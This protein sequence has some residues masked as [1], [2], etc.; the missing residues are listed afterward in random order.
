MEK[1]NK[2][3]RVIVQVVRDSGNTAT[4]TLGSLEEA[5]GHIEQLIGSEAEMAAGS[6][7]EK[8]AKDK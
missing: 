6:K 5:A 8:T 2:I 4:K 1:E 3:V 7:P